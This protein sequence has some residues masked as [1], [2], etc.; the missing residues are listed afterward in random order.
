MMIELLQK[1]KGVLEEEKRE[2]VKEKLQLEENLRAAE[3]T[4][5]FLFI[6][7]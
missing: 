3:G 4:F 2:V 7:L 1:E 5:F 6:H